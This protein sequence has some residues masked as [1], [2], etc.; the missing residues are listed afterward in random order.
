MEFALKLKTI[1]FVFAA[2]FDVALGEEKWFPK[3]DISVNFP[4]VILNDINLLLHNT[5]SRSKLPIFTSVM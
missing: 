4:C 1:Y 3:R 2:L 5:A